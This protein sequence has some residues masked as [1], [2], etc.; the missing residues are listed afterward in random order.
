[1][2]CCGKKKRRKLQR[3]MDSK[4]LKNSLKVM[5]AMKDANPL[6]LNDNILLD[7]HKKCHMLYAGNLKHRPPNKS[8]INSIV[9]LHNEIVKEMEKR[10]MKHNTPLKKL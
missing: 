4:F 5:K 8:F 9:L 7:Y 1:M 3:L 2:G 10:K 6:K